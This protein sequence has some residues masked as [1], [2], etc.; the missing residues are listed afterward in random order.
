MAMPDR[1]TRQTSEP[2]RPGG[3]F[4][5]LER[6]MDLSDLA[7]WQ[8]LISAWREKRLSAALGRRLTPFFK[9]L[10]YLF[11]NPAA[12]HIKLHC[13]AYVSPNNDEAEMA[14]VQR[15]FAAYRRM[16][17][18]QEGANPLY[19]PSAMWR[20]Q[21]HRS[22]AFLISGLAGGNIHKFHYFLTN[23]GAW[24]EYTGVEEC[25]LIQNHMRLAV[26]RRYLQNEIFHNLLKLWMY[27]YNGRKD[28]SS[29]WRPGFGNLAGARVDGVLVTVDSF[30]GEIYG[31]LLAQLLHQPRPVVAELGGGC[32][33]LAYYTVRHLGDFCY[34]DFDL[35][36]TLCLAAYYLMLAFPQKRALLYGEEE[37]SPAL[38]QKYDFIFL[39]S[40]EIA[41]IGS[42]TVELF[43]NETSLGEMTREAISNYLRYITQATTYFFHINRDR[44]RNIFA[45]HETSLLGHEYPV[46][47]DRFT[48]VFRYPDLKHLVFYGGRVDFNSDAFIYL[49]E[50][51]HE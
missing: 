23:F 15:I 20:A 7:V 22:Y 44:R 14:V 31:S 37:Y 45:D 27:Y 17:R 39:P 11:H 16:T 10:K 30:F 1:L 36:E 42:G 43:V 2:L 40:Y 6:T 48:L 25:T 46:P 28:V 41:K 50:K 35:P 47:T 32:G 19:Q 49:Y 24:K 18:D 12:R 3:D 26:T 34:L 9:G 51:K 4:Y 29:L 5:S 33:R 38:H 13:P 8:R 21:L